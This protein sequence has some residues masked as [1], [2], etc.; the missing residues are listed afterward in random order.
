MPVDGRRLMM[1]RRIWARRSGEYKVELGRKKPC[2]WSWTQ[3]KFF[4]LKTV[5]SQGFR[6][7]ECKGEAKIIIIK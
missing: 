4:L 5:E 1:R 6:S 3:L 2:V 7:D